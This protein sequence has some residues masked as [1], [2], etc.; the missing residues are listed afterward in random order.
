[1]CQYS[2]TGWR[3][4]A[5]L[6]WQNSNTSLFG[7]IITSLHFPVFPIYTLKVLLDDIFSLIVSPF[8]FITYS[9]TVHFFLQI[10]KF[11]FFFIFFF[12]LLFLQPVPQ[13]WCLYSKR[14][15]SLHC[16]F[17]CPCNLFL[18]CDFY[19]WF[20]LLIY[21]F[22]LYF[23]SAVYSVYSIFHFTLSP[24]VFLLFSDDSNLWCGNNCLLSLPRRVWGTKLCSFTYT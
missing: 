22:D 18:K 12:S 21:L 19:M 2:P 13:W 16:L 9:S 11:R 14:R 6:S 3:F 15:S 24:Y 23:F 7:W 5:P 20:F 4:S 10:L 1:M 8:N 17:G